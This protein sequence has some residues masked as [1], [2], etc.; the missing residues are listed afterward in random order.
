MA[1]YDTEIEGSV[2]GIVADGLGVRMVVNGIDVRYSSSPTNKLSTPAGPLTIQ[3]LLD[4]SA[5]PG[6]TLPGFESSTAIIVGKYDTLTQRLSASEITI[7][8]SENVIVGGITRN[9]NGMP[10]VLEVNG[11]AIELIED[12]RLRAAPVRNEFGFDVKPETVTVDMPATA[13]GYFSGGKFYAF[14]LEVDGPALLVNPSP[15]VSI[16]RAQGRSRGAEYDLDVRGAIT[17]SHV[18]VGQTQRIEIYRVDDVGGTPLETRI[19]GVAMRVIAGGFGKWRFDERITAGRG[20]L[21]NPPT[22]I[23]AYNAT[24]P[25]TAVSAEFAVEIRTE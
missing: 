19:G 2:S 15:Q 24:A 13:E 4:S 5:L 6:R 25:A 18:T 20:F 16:L 7:E 14:V 21:A 9:D 23:R 17:T 1:L 3:Q 10:R 12:P 22:V 8:P 11:V